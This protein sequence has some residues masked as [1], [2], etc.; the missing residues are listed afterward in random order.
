[1]RFYKHDPSDKHELWCK[2]QVVHTNNSIKTETWKKLGVKLPAPS[3]L[4]AH[5]ST[6]VT[7]I[8]SIKPEIM[9]NLYYSMNSSLFSS[10]KWQLAHKWH[11]SAC[12]IYVEFVMVLPVISRWPFQ[13]FTL[14]PPTWAQKRRSSRWPLPCSS[15]GCCYLIFHFVGSQPSVYR[16]HDLIP[17]VPTPSAIEA[18]HNDLLGAREV[19]SPVDPEGVIDFLTT[20]PCVPGG[21][22]PQNSGPRSLASRIWNTIIADSFQPLMKGRLLN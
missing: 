2:S 8:I 6:N 19:S 3:S 4:V 11:T 17:L 1:M 12:K 15:P 7:A 5:S 16:V 10:I 9:A 18:G 22:E 14:F 20:G 21:K 13:T